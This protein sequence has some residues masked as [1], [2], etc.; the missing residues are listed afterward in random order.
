M[1]R[2]LCTAK[3]FSCFVLIANLS[4]SC[5]HIPAIPEVII[6]NRSRMKCH[7]MISPIS[8]IASFEMRSTATV[9]ERWTRAEGAG[10][11][12]F[13]GIHGH[14]GSGRPLAALVGGVFCTSL[15][16]CP[17][18]NV[19]FLDS[20]KT[21]WQERQIYVKLLWLCKLMEILGK[22]SAPNPW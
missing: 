1:Q 19:S 11:W 4:P 14:L 2:H 13:G 6:W 16:C 22:W 7:E 20:S 12:S 18:N 17:K 3:P 8:I 9:L 21:L 15:L 5:S 10:L